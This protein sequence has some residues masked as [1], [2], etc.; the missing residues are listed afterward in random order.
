MTTL[1]MLRATDAMT[2]EIT[3]EKRVY[4]QYTAECFAADWRMS[5]KTRESNIYVGDVLMFGYERSGV[6]R[7]F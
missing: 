6:P 1:I 4:S 2:G 3:K 5:P 7:K